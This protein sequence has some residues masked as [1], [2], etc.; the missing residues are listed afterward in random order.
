MKRVVLFAALGLALLASR[1]HPAHYRRVTHHYLNDTT[2]TPGAVDPG[3]DT[4][5]VCVRGYV[6]QARVRHV[7]ESVKQQVYSAYGTRPS[8]TPP[9]EPA[10]CEVDH[11]ISLELGG[12]NDPI[13]LWPEPYPD[14]LEKDQLENALHWMACHG[15]IDLGQAQRGI[16]R[17]WVAFRDSL[18]RAGNWISPIAG[19]NR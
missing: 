2:V 1:Q 12:S 3:A 15:R 8:G 6:S 11:L 7:S 13:N 9:L 17:D 10:C 18:M 4:S 19:S 5:V 14:A 16:A